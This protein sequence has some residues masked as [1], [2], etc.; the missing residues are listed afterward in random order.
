MKTL[1]TSL[2]AG[3]CS[4]AVGAALA[5]PAQAQQAADPQDTED[6]DRVWALSPS[7][8]SAGLKASRMYR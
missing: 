2:M 3:V 5:M 1:T 8:R 6:A 7:R 4:F